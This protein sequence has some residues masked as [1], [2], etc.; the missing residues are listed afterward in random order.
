MCVFDPPS[1]SFLAIASFNSSRLPRFPFSADGGP[2]GGAHL[3]PTHRVSAAL[4]GV[5]AVCARLGRLQDQARQWSVRPSGRVPDRPGLLRHVL[6]RRLRERVLRGR[7]G[8]F[9]LVGLGST[10]QKLQKYVNLH[11]VVD[12]RI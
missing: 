5:C 3:T 6:R 7:Q 1:F 12:D 11:A 9:R 8:G 10:E 2:G 4:G